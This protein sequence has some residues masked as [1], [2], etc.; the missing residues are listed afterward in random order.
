MR[1]FGHES[2]RSI[3]ANAHQSHCYLG[4]ALHQEHTLASFDRK[5]DLML[6]GIVR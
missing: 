1:A 5:R 6:I 3:A 2:F 4:L